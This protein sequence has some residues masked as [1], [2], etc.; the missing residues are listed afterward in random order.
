MSKRHNIIA[1][2]LLSSAAAHAGT[3]K[4][5]KHPAVHVETD[6]DGFPVVGNIVQGK[7]GPR[8]VVHVTTEPAVPEPHFIAR[9]FS[10][11]GRPR[12]TT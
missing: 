2:I 5:K 3:N 10:V 1:L 12:R 9:I 4:V 7:G 8:H 11:N 6:E